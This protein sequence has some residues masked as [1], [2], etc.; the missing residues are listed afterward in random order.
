MEQELNV[1]P[2]Q[3]GA[4]NCICS[5]TCNQ[6]GSF[7]PAVKGRFHLSVFCLGNGLQRC[8]V[9]IDATIGS[10]IDGELNVLTNIDPA[11]TV[12]SLEELVHVTVVFFLAHV[13][14]PHQ[15]CKQV[16]AELTK[17]TGNRLAVTLREHTAHTV[18]V[19]E[20]H[21]LAHR[22]EVAEGSDVICKVCGVIPNK[23]AVTNFAPGYKVGAEFCGSCP[24]NTVGTRCI[25][26]L[27]KGMHKAY[28]NG[29]QTNANV[30]TGNNALGS[31]LGVIVRQGVNNEIRIILLENLCNL[32]NEHEQVTCGAAC[33][34]IACVGGVE[35]VRS[36]AVFTLTVYVFIVL[37]NRNDIDGGV[38]FKSRT[39]ILDG[40][41]EVCLTLGRIQGEAGVCGSTTAGFGQR[42]KRVNK[43]GTVVPRA[44][45]FAAHVSVV[46]VN[47][48]LVAPF[49][50]I[51][52]T[53]PVHTARFKVRGVFENNTVG[54]GDFA[55]RNGFKTGHKV[56]NTAKL[57]KELVNAIQNT[58]LVAANNGHA[59]ILT[60]GDGSDDESIVL[61]RGIDG[62]CDGEC[63][64]CLNGNVLLLQILCKLFACIYFALGFTR[65]DGNLGQCQCVGV[66]S[67]GLLRVF[68]RLFALGCLRVLRSLRCALPTGCQIGRKRIACCNSFGNC[69]ASGE[70]RNHNC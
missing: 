10:H 63:A 45:V 5:V 33:F 2:L 55:I 37:R 50:I 20:S 23:D 39:Q 26:T 57:L 54:N 6:L 47:A 67:V 13:G 51:S 31:G 15:F 9:N 69:R 24:S 52:Y 25:G 40:L 46:G 12:V 27:G 32:V 58:A 68:F 66:D 16:S 28:A 41:F 38:C 29:A 70:R 22:T 8:F 19:V 4:V 17:L 3:C 53:I 61:K 60:G 43:V 35:C 49:C 36:Q 44:T 30:V 34:F 21:V 11:C 14:V 48:L 64:V 62:E 42:A 1:T 7:P 59:C 18:F 65:K 56:A